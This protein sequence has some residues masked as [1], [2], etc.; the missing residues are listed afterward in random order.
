MQRQNTRE[1]PDFTVKSA[2][3]V[4]ITAAILLTPFTVNNFL[5]GRNLLGI[6]TLT[7][8]FLCAISAYICYRGQ[9]H[10]GINLFGITPALIIATVIALNQLD[11]AGSYWALLGVIAFYFILPEKP[12]W[13]TNILF[14]GIMVPVGWNVLDPAVATRFFAVLLGTSFFSFLSIREI[15]KQHH[16]LKEQAVTDP[17]TGLY[18]RSLL[19]KHLE[20]AIHQS[21]R[22]DTEMALIMLDL[23]HFKKVNDELGHDTGDSLLK[24]MGE[25]LSNYFRTTDTVFRVGGEEFLALIYGTNKAN[26]LLIA[27]KLR[28]E[29]EQLTLIPNRITTVSIGVSALQSDMN[30]E[31]WM[32]HCDNNLYRAKSN[33]R[34]QVTA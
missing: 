19:Q 2:Q 14:V 10:L 21:G 20:S 4:A 29:I 11:V 17:L 1:L 30:W 6:F 24:G 23:D 33:G 28:E 25:F 7:I 34:N 26:T 27:E 3:G 15:H 8:L 32:K 22:T 13:I 5:Q 16:L 9:Y 31:Q 18:N 12:A